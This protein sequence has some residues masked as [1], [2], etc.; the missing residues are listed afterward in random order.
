MLETLSMWSNVQPQLQP[1]PFRMKIS[2]LRNHLERSRRGLAF[3]PTWFS[4]AACC[5][6]HNAKHVLHAKR[7][8]R[9]TVSFTFRHRHQEIR[10]EHS[11]REPETFHAHIVP[12]QWSANQFIPIKVGIGR[13]SRHFVARNIFP[14]K[15]QRDARDLSAVSPTIVPLERQRNLRPVKV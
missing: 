11:P 10:F 14:V 1:H 4:V 12:A 3:F 9:P 5:T 6:R 13:H 2:K 15:T 7:D 8:V